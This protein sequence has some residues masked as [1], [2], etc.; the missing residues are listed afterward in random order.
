VPSLLPKTAILVLSTS[1]CCIKT[2]K[3]FFCVL[4]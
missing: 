1:G 3:S 4:F 2:A